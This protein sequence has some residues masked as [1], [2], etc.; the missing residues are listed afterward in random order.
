MGFD[1]GFGARLSQNNGLTFTYGPTGSGIGETHV[2]LMGDPTLR[3][4]VVAPAS[5]LSAAA[6][7][8]DV[9][10]SWTASPQVGSLQASPV[11]G[12]NVYR[13]DTAN[14]PFTLLNTSGPVTTTTYTDTGVGALPHTYQVRAV[15]LQ[16]TPSGTY[17]NQSQGIYQA[18]DSG[19]AA[20]TVTL[21]APAKTAGGIIPNDPIINAQGIAF[22]GN[23]TATMTLAADAASSIPNDSGLTVTFLLN[24]TPITGTAA[25][26]NPATAP[27]YQFPN[28]TLAP[29]Y[30]TL[31]AIATDGQGATTASNSLPIY[32]YS[33]PESPSQTDT[34]NLQNRAYLSNIFSGGALAAGWSDISDKSNN[35]FLMADNLGGNPA[36]VDLKQPGSAFVLT[37]HAH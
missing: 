3:L 34:G 31:S 15:C 18:Y 1:L 35:G 37:P 30:Y 14:S 24:G 19:H 25:Q 17:Y 28:L 7:G 2:A 5:G 26:P 27:P 29:G 21:V 10:L 8:A 36:S 32:V 33:I 4:N 16:T 20:P 6:S 13:Q 11:L 9:A 12:Y 22:I 23:P